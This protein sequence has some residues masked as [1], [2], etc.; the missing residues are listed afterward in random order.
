MVVSPLYF[1]GGVQITVIGENF[2]DGSK[3]TVGQVMV[4]NITVTSGTQLIFQAPKQSKPGI[5]PIWVWMAAGGRSTSKYV[6]VY[7][8]AC[9]WHEVEIKAIAV[10]KTD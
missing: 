3:I 7:L 8:C 2:T 4:N 5:Y 6:C 9:F 1:A 10:R